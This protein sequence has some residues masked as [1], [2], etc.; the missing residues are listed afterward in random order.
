MIPNIKL[1]TVWFKILHHNDGDNVYRTRV[2]GYHYWD[3]A[4]NARKKLQP[5]VIDVVKVRITSEGY[6][7]RR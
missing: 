3:A 5:L 4:K 6:E 2:R 7:E 1:Y